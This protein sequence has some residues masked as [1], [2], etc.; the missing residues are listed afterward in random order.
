[1]RKLIIGSLAMSGIAAC[2]A[3]VFVRRQR[4]ILY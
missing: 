3:A 1:M 4:R 2:V